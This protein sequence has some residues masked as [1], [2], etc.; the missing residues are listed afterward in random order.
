MES[1]AYCGAR[2]FWPRR[3]VQRDCLP[4]TC[5]AA[6]ASPRA[7]TGPIRA[8]RPRSDKTALIGLVLVAK[9][10]SRLPNLEYIT[11]SLT[12]AAIPRSSWQ[13]QR[14]AKTP[15]I[16]ASTDRDRS[17][18][19]PAFSRS[20]CRLRGVNGRPCA[21]SENPRNPKIN[22]ALLAAF[23]MLICISLWPRTAYAVLGAPAR[24]VT[25]DQALYGGKPGV[26]HPSELHG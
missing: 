24:S 19:W 12:M 5:P 25:D 26:F 13:S 8:I 1:R 4:K 15:H 16:V 9:L 7:L 17:C 11:D 14:T 18:R 23:A 10:V 3:L 2:L 22:T 21:T 20:V 6:A